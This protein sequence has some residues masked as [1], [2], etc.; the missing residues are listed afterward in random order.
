MQHILLVEDNK[1][2]ASMLR[3]FL[4]RE[5][6]EVTIKYD[7]EQAIDCLKAGETFD[8]IITDLIMPEN[9]GFDV[10][11]FI[12][13]H[14]IDTPTIVISGGGITADV[15]SALKAAQEIASATIAKPVD[16]DALLSAIKSLT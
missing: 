11:F 5:N 1:E 15:Q 7:G 4:M 10:L 8:L 12:K 13:K 6:Y 2:V 14:N 9:D 16:F 3:E